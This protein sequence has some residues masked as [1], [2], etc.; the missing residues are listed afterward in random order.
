[1]VTHRVASRVVVSDY[2][3]ITAGTLG[4]PAVP[5]SGTGS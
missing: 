3:P 1:M 4:V 2:M 5:F